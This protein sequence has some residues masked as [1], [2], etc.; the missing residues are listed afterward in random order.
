MLVRR[1]PCDGRIPIMQK[2][3][4]VIQKPSR[5]VFPTIKIEYNDER[6]ATG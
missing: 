2:K 1:E 4:I 5:I 6:D 3:V